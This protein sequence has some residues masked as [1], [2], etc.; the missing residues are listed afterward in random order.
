MGLLGII[1]L[2]KHVPGFAEVGQLACGAIGERKSVLCCDDNLVLVGIAG[3]LD[4][5][6]HSEVPSS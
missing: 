5:S 1:L 3:V 2:R 4:I 6:G